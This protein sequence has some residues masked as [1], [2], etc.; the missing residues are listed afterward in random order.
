VGAIPTAYQGYRRDKTLPGSLPALQLRQLLSHLLQLLS[1]R[2]AGS[3][4]LTCLFLCGS[5]LRARGLQLSSKSVG[6]PGLAGRSN[7]GKA[8]KPHQHPPH[9]S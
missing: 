5:S 1:R 7:Q 6:V 9:C 3:L 2:H 8:Q 4:A